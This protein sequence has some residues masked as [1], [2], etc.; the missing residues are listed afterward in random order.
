MNQYKFEV[1]QF[2]QI[3]FFDMKIPFKVI[4]INSKGITLKND[5]TRLELKD[6]KESDL[7]KMIIERLQ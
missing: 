3:E 6:Y 1:G 2:Y 7:E 5:L 4:K